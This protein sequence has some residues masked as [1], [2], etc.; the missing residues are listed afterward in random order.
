MMQQLHYMFLFKFA[1]E[2]L[3]MYAWLSSH[4]YLPNPVFFGT[5]A[6][7][8]KDTAFTSLKQKKNICI[9]RRVLVV[10]FV[11]CTTKQNLHKHKKAQVKEKTL[12]YS[13]RNCTWKIG[14]IDS[15]CCLVLIKIYSRYES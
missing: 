6:F 11:D 9:D 5:V 12:K 1:M 3:F 10:S 8:M 13:I 7:K 15:D 2:N 14:R 4:Y